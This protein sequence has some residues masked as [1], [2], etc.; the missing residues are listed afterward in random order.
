M[1]SNMWWGP[2][3]PLIPYGKGRVINPIVTVGFIFFNCDDHPQYKEFRPW[4]K[5]VEFPCGNNGIMEFVPKWNIICEHCNEMLDRKSSLQTSLL[6]PKNSLITARS[7]VSAFGTWRW[8]LR[9][10]SKYPKESE[11]EFHG[12][13]FWALRGSR[14]SGSARILIGADAS[15]APQLSSI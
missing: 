2:K 7:Q 15:C 10:I 12:I 1:E 6:P 13:Y 14:T 5:W 9:E 8:Q 4:Y 3:S 11:W